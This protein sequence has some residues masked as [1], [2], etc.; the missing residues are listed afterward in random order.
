MLGGRVDRREGMNLVRLSMLLMGEIV[1]ISSIREATK[2]KR[3]INLLL[4]FF[5]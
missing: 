5:L 2:E 4:S 3:K 1:M